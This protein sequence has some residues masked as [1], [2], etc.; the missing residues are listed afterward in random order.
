MG[1]VAGAAVVVVVVVVGGPRSRGQ[2]RKRARVACDQNVLVQ[3]ATFG[4]PTG[5]LAAD[6]TQADVHFKG[7]WFQRATA[8]YVPGLCQSRL[9]TDTL[10][11]EG[12]DRSVMTIPPSDHNATAR[13]P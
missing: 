1:S 4:G 8:G 6:W 2:G 9:E 7:L 13:L 5:R 12:E 10:G 3:E 11:E